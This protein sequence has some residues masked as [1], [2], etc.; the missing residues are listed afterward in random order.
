[1]NAATDNT[2]TTL[3]IVFPG[4]GSQSIGMLS[5]LAASYPLVNETFAQA[6]D[7]LGYDLWKLSQDGPED[8]LN[9][10]DRTQPAMLAA[11]V[12]VWRV[13]QQ[14]NGMLPGVMAGHS[15]GEYSALVCAGAMEFA[16]AVSL[17]EE[18][19]R[20]M[21]SAVPAGVGAM[22]AILGLHDE[23]VA[24]VCNRAAESE[25]VSPVNF[26]SPGQV[27]IAGNADAVQR[28]I[29]LAKEAGAKRALPL[30]VSVPSHCSLMQ[31]A[32]EQFAERLAQTS[33]S[34]PSIPVIQNVD[35]VRHDQ[36]DA[37]RENLEKQL[38]RP[39]Q[40]V[41]S[42][43]NMGE[44]GVTR[45]VEAGPGKVLAGLCKRIDK[46]IASAAVFDPASLTAA[47]DG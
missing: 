41:L 7:V 24:D 10:T 39:V 43:Q 15:L 13:W 17:V 27:V 31:P 36:P 22:A 2:D 33:I 34:T 35:A 16:D 6:S 42:V 28:A 23:A 9:R 11:G 38:Y 19:G 20:C 37:I 25:V 45:I 47:L 1:M 5:E 32:A 12:A 18:R 14:E 21:Q 3:A 4:Q 46:S 44:Q 8:E 29:G 30:A 26:N 40:W